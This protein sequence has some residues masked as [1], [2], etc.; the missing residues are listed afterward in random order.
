MH[1]RS[2]KLDFTISKLRSR[3]WNIVREHLK[4]EVLDCENGFVTATQPP[5][6]DVMDRYIQISCKNRSWK[7][8]NMTPDVF[9]H[10][11][12]QNCRLKLTIFKYGMKLKTVDQYLQYIR[13]TSKPHQPAS[14]ASQI[15]SQSL[16]AENLHAGSTVFTPESDSDGSVELFDKYPVIPK[17]LAPSKVVNTQKKTPKQ[18]IQHSNHSEQR[19]RLT[20]GASAKKLKDYSSQ[21]QTLRSDS[22]SLIKRIEMIESRL[23]SDSQS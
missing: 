20:Q 9:E 15:L 17:P 12:Q 10:I 14:Q 19:Q 7:T 11:K 5:T 13:R 3:L 18:H 8:R 21:L 6:I 23:K 2:I 4:P 1:L 22:S 16:E